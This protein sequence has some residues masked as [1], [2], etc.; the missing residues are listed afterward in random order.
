MLGFELAELYET[1]T[2]SLKQA[3]NRNVDRFPDNFMFKLTKK[4]C[5]QVIT[6]CDN[7]LTSVKFSPSMPYAFT[8]QG[9]AMLSSVLRNK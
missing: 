7:L 8:E 3:V 5:Q 1:D 9:V 4:E 2:G 6:N